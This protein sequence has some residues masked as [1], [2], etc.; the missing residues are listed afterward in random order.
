M[1]SRFRGIGAFLDR[2][3]EI[4][5]RARKILGWGR[6]DRGSEILRIPDDVNRDSAAM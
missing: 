1:S 4:V 6:L 3:R 5:R 2:D